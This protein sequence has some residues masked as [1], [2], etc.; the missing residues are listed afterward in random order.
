MAPTVFKDCV[1]VLNG[2]F[3]NFSHANLAQLITDFGGQISKKINDKVTH[4]VASQK[5]IDRNSVK[6]CRA[7]ERSHIKIVV[8]QWV[9]DSLENGAKLDEA[10]Y[11]IQK[12]V[13]VSPLRKKRP[14]PKSTLDADQPSTKKREG[15]QYLGHRIHIPLDLPKGLEDS[16]HHWKVYV[17]P[18]GLIYDA[19][20]SLSNV[21]YNNNKFYRIQL[22]QDEESLAYH[23]W[24][25]WGRVGTRGSHALLECGPLADAKTIFNRRFWEKTG[26][27]WANRL[28]PPRDHKYTFI[29]RKYVEEGDKGSDVE[30]KPISQISSEKKPHA[31]LCEPKSK[32]HGAIQGLMRLIFNEE[33]FD[34]T[35]YEMAY[36]TNTLPLGNLSKRTLMLGYE[37]LKEIGEFFTRTKGRVPRPPDFNDVLEELTNRYYTVIPHVFGRDIPLLITNETHLKRELALMESLGDI[38]IANEISKAAIARKDDMHLLDREFAGLGL[39][40]MTPW[41]RIAPPEAPVSGYMFG[42]GIYLADMSTKSANYCHSELSD[43]S[44]LLL[45][46]EA[47][48]GK[49]MLELLRADYDAHVSVELGGLLSVMGKGLVAPMKWKDA[50]CVHADLKGVSMVSGRKIPT[51]VR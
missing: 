36:D 35:L 23:V 20:L 9:Q 48:L 28:D 2:T 34:A 33:Y 27:L 44:A 15:E 51:V 1:V 26:L 5:E 42:K 14:L 13:S 40:E 6:I 8:N 30:P 45:L 43:D 25:R 47:E 4:L 18:C 11:L 22:V 3:T 31:G 39:N 12:G 38:E 17:G 49:P 41:L 46:C 16:W 24:T 19:T 21:T 50:G 7:A 10:P 29:E 32:L 37:C